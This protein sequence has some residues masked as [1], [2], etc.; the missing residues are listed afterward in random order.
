[1]PQDLVEVTGDELYVHLVGD[2]YLVGNL[3]PVFIVLSK[4]V[5]QGL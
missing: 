4:E 1:M 5:Q 2:E 3:A